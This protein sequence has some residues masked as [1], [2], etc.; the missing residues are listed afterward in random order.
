[1]S[2]GSEHRLGPRAEAFEKALRVEREAVARR[3][4]ASG[5][6][7]STRC[8]S[9]CRSHPTGTAWDELAFH[10]TRLTLQRFFADRQAGHFGLHDLVIE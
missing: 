8:G 4:G 1:M 3:L 5:R 9:I 10:T 7:S 2:A 6:P